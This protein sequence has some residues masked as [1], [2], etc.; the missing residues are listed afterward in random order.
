MREPSGHLGALRKRWPD[1]FTRVAKAHVGIDGLLP[2]KEWDKLFYDET[3]LGELRKIPGRDIEAL[4]LWSEDKEI[5]CCSEKMQNAVSWEV[6][7]ARSSNFEGLGR[8]CVYIELS[9]YIWEAACGNVEIYGAWACLDRDITAKTK[10]L[11]VLMNTAEGRIPFTLELDSFCSRRA[12]EKAIKNTCL[13]GLKSFFTRINPEDVDLEMPQFSRLINLVA[14]VA[15]N[16]GEFRRF[17]PSMITPGDRKGIVRLRPVTEARCP[18]LYLL[19][20]VAVSND[21]D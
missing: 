7:V 9:G 17:A 3:D 20:D 5:Y 10:H 2:E 11:K 13:P 4:F 14:H 6:P 16:H 21:R 18:S 15:K 1:F 12:L 8:K 19:E